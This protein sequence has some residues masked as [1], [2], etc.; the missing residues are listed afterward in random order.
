MGTQLTLTEKLGDHMK[1]LT[2]KDY[3]TMTIGSEFLAEVHGLLLMNFNFCQEDTLALIINFEGW[4]HDRDSK[5]STAEWVS[6][7][8]GRLK[9]PLYMSSVKKYW[10]RSLLQGISEVDFP[11]KD[12]VEHHNVLDAS[13]RYQA[14]FFGDDEVYEGQYPDWESEVYH[15]LVDNTSR[16]SPDIQDFMEIHKEALYEVH[17]NRGLPYEGVQK[18][19]ECGILVLKGKTRSTS[20]CW[21]TLDHWKTRAIETLMKDY[22]VPEPASQDWIQDQGDKVIQKIRQDNPYVLGVEE[23]H[24]LMFGNVLPEGWE[25]SINEVSK[26]LFKDHGILPEEIQDFIENMEGRDLRNICVGAPIQGAIILHRM[27][28]TSIED[29]TIWGNKMV[30]LVTDVYNM[31]VFSW[32]DVRSQT[33]DN[34]LK[35]V[36]QC[37]KLGLQI[38]AIHRILLT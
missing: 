4:I 16:T 14:I 21:A 27:M 17:R 11:A 5:N 2:F 6:I 29:F 23:L 15:I 3:P 33:S 22:N 32:D 18:M 10:K 13:L 25:E 20:Y 34:F 1:N 26:I 38:K 12:F 36:Q 24:R 8:L 35:E 9:D 28:R 30:D 7:Q 31:N 19:E 37:P